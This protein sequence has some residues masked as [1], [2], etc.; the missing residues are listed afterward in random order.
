MP[1][2]HLLMRKEEIDSIKMKDN[3]VA[4]VFDVLLATSTITAGLHFGAREVIP[5]LNGEEAQKEAEHRDEETY[6]LVGEYEGKTIEG[7][8]DPNPLQLR[9]VLEGKS[10]ILSTTNGT[11]AIK[12]AADANRVYISSLLNGK[13]VAKKLNCEVQEETVVVICSGSG[14]EFCLE[15]FYGAGYFL[16]CLV[17]NEDKD[18]QLTDAAQSA[19]LFYKGMRDKSNEVLL[20]SRVG[21]LLA[22]Y[23]YEEE[24]RFVGN[25]G[26]I[27]I[28]PYLV[29]G[30]IVI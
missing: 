21:K 23:G 28:V 6:V 13:A 17:R 29:N 5:V 27:P 12:K 3:K 15:D 11:V 22:K 24:V 30:R 19:L 9:E 26:S 14:G 4:V 2:L 20:S 16:D 7:F 1:K 25:H 8:L 18:W 10:M